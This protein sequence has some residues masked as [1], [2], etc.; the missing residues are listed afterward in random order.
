MFLHEIGEGNER[1]TDDR[2]ATPVRE[3]RVRVETARGHIQEN[4]IQQRL[5]RGL[6]V[7]KRREREGGLEEAKGGK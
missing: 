2:I 6:S 5:G 1:A 7:C 3:L 4:L